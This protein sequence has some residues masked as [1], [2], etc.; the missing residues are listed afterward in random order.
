MTTNL[1]VDVSPSGSGNIDLDGS[2]RSSCDVIIK[3]GTY[4]TIEAIPALGYRFSNWSGD[5]TGNENPIDIKLL[6]D[7]VIIAHFLPKSREFISDDGTLKIIIPE[8]VIALD[9]EGDLLTSLELIVS[10]PIQPPEANIIGLAYNLEPNGAT[11][12][13][14]ITIIWSYDPANIPQ[15]IAEEDL[16]LAYYDGDSSDWVVL[17]SEV[18]MSTNAITALVS[19]FTNFAIMAIAA[20]PS[21]AAFGISSLSVSP[22]EVNIGEEVSINALVT[23]TGE[24]QGS[25][26]ISLKIDGIIEETKELTLA[27]GAGET[28]T[29]TTLKDKA[30]TY[31]VDVNGLL[32]SFIVKE[33][34]PP[35]PPVTPQS[36]TLSKVNWFIFGPI[37]IAVVIFLAIFSLIRLR[38]RDFFN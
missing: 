27:G 18:D 28:I 23:N 36:T 6:E 35:L 17:P 11:F 5:M 2:T 37:I 33:I 1:T 12:D 30:D 19:H 13:P 22:F 21:P 38:R 29:F 14:P 31:S 9:E 24:E 25:Y 20:L 10:N 8:G 34:P 15:R 16:V 4:L 3:H 7:T 32:S 26:T